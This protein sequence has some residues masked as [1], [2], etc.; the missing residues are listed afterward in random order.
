MRTM[1]GNIHLVVW[2]D[3]LYLGAVDVD[4]SI[5]SNKANILIPFANSRG[6]I[7]SHLELK[8]GCSFDP[9]IG[10]GTRPGQQ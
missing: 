6:L 8:V 7:R 3:A 10:S 1:R 9:G 2:Q 5:F 4:R